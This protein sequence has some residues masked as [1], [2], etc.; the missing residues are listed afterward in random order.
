MGR[1]RLRVI[2]GLRAAVC[3]RLICQAHEVL[4]G[5]TRLLLLSTPELPHLA[6]DLREK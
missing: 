3:V 1:A 2:F 6:H 4:G 5:A